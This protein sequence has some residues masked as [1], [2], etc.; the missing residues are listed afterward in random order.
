LRFTVMEGP[1]VALPDGNI[2]FYNWTCF[3]QFS[4]DT[5]TASLNIILEMFGIELNT[6]KLQIYKTIQSNHTTISLK[7]N[8]ENETGGL[9]K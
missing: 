3:L 7:H 8:T 2:S 9:A 5:Q 6:I 4:Q 1:Q